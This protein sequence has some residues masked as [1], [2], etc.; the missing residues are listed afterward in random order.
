[1]K[2]SPVLSLLIVVCLVLQVPAE[3][4]VASPYS[5][6]ILRL[7]AGKDL[8]ESRNLEKFETR[9][10]RDLENTPELGVRVHSLQTSE[11]F[12]L[13]LERLRKLKGLATRIL[14]EKADSELL[15]ASVEKA[16]AET[17]LN[18]EDAPVIQRTRLAQSIGFWRKALFREATKYLDLA[19]RIHPEGSID[20]SLDALLAGE[21]AERFRRWL[22]QSQKPLVFECS[23]DATMV[24][25]EA[26]LILNGFELGTRRH[27]ELVGGAR[28]SIVANAPGYLPRE[29]SF[30]CN[31]A[32]Q[33]IEALKLVPGVGFGPE[34]LL[35]VSRAA[36]SFGVGSLIVVDSDRL[37]RVH[38]FLYTSGVGLEPIPWEKPVTLASLDQEST[39][40]RL[41]VSLGALSE[42]IESHRKIPLKAGL[43]VKEKFQGSLL[44]DLKAPDRGEPKEWYKKNEFWW[45]L[46]GLGAAA[47]AGILVSR[48]TEKSNGGLR[49]GIE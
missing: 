2:T 24:P 13:G 15:V 49:G 22:S 29:L 21:E 11:N 35:R 34:D 1:M 44:G 48:G 31:G 45:L 17:P 3:A 18:P 46:G 26:S 37:G 4:L 30:E 25:V 32:G 23:L 8:T 42:V 7:R 12:R 40:E 38:L 43:G 28:Y 27:F 33:W 6:G 5:L 36:K 9:L 41:P 14:N 47:L 16:L 39:E 19:Q 10:L 20:E